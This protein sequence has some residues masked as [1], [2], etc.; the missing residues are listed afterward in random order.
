MTDLGAALLDLEERNRACT[1]C[2]LRAGCLQ[3]VV[4]DG[5]VNA[6]VVIVGEAP[7]GGE[8]LEG[9]PFVGPGGQLLDRILG[10]VGLSRE[11]CYITNVVKCRPPANRDPQPDEIHT[12]TTLW[13]G[14]QL[15]LLRPK[16]ILTLGNTATQTLLQTRQGITKLRGQW[17]P[18]VQVLPGG[19]KHAAWLM[20]MLHPAYLLRVDT[21][22]PGG[23]KS[24]TWRDIQEVAAVLRGEHQPVTHPPDTSQP[25][26]F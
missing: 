2:R 8:D 23:P 22:A 13:L 14:A 12:C 20:P 10:S 26:L 16:V 3:V 1:A 25:R 21:R 15:G 24:L 17:F 18:F 19:H 7:G 6:E 5:P 4:S 9:H 11:A